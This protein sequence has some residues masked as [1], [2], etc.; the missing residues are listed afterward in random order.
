[1][2]SGLV[3]T[4]VIITL[5]EF[6]SKLEKQFICLRDVLGANKN[7]EGNWKDSSSKQKCLSECTQEF[8]I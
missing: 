6:H 5:Y 2:Q 1:V 8:W 3:I 7:S 4:N